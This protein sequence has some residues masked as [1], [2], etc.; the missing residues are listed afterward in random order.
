MWDRGPGNAQ[1]SY[2]LSGKEKNPYYAGNQTLL[3]HHIT[4]SFTDR[5]ILAHS[6]KKYNSKH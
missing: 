1:S 6:L 2:E 3:S 5:A 4:T